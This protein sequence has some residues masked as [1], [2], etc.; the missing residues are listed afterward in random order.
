MAQHTEVL[1]PTLRYT[2]TDF[3]ALRAYLNR[4]PLSQ[5]RTHYYSEEDLIDLDCSTDSQ[6]T[7]RLEELQERLVLRANDSNPHL[8]ELLKT[9][10]RSRT[11]SPKLIDFLVQGADRDLATPRPTDAV[12]AW[13][14][15][16]IAQAL[17]SEAVR[18]LRELIDLIDVRGSGWWKPLRRLGAGRA[19]RIE[20]W[21]DHYAS[22]LG[23][24]QPAVRAV[25]AGDLV[26]LA[27]DSPV[28]APIERLVLPRDLDGQA[29]RN[30]AP[31]FCQIAARHDYA[32]IDAYLTKF[33]HQEKTRR[34]YQKEIERFL[35]W[36]ITVRGTALSSALHD[37]CEAFKDFLGAIPG[38]WIG[39]KCLRRDPRWRPFG[40]QLSPGSQRYAVQAVR[41]FFSWLVDVRY[42]GG[43]PWATVSDPRVAQAILPMQIDKALPAA[44]WGKLA[45]PGGLLDQVCTTPEASLQARYKLRGASATRSIAAQFRLARAALLLIG[46]TGLR[47]EEAAYATR[48]KLKPV[49]DS[50]ALW[51]LDVLGKRNRWRTV[52]PTSRVI[53]ALNAH[54]LDRGRDFSYGLAEIPLLSPLSAP[55]TANA[56]AKHHDATGAMKESGFSPDGLYQVV[57]TA[58]KRI[59]DDAAFDLSNAERVHLRRAAPHAFRHTFG[60]L[61]VAGEVPLDVVQKVLGHASLQTTT[62][63]VQAE[64]KRSIR[65][66][67]KFFKAD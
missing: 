61:A 54:W 38:A 44:L 15:T 37:D 47:R 5:I 21:L 27:P 23:A 9:A 4:I 39:P 66:L 28:L 26:V 7:A 19:A 12:A 31:A 36:C 34:A 11:W 46:D 60:T 14:K 22:S 40:G 59:A 6:L 32:A 48:D 13:F 56:Q 33:R 20:A 57:K 65:E 2:R 42:L 25:S 64:K 10:R 30:R 18:T 17:R 49:P 24:R 67:G 52:F 51:E 8:A 43:N 58:L 62:I 63:Y 53:Q 50:A 55:A 29:G 16:P 35:L 41:T 45:A 3:T 1:L